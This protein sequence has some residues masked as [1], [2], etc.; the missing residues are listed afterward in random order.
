MSEQAVHHALRRQLEDRRAR[1]SASVAREGRDAD[2]VQLLRQVDSVLARI[3]TED[4]ARCLVCNEHVDESELRFNPLAEYCLCD[5]SAEQ[6]QALQ[7]DL[8]RARRIQAALLPDPELDSASWQAS[9]RYE[10]AGIVSG[11]F[12][13][14]WVPPGDA[15]FVCFAVGDVAGKGVAASLLMAHL[16]AAIRS[17]IDADVPL[18]DLVRRVNRKLLGASIPTHYATLACGRAHANGLV[19][20]VNAGHCPPLVL[21]ALG[22]DR[23][24]ATGFPVGLVD[25][26][27]YEVARLRLD[28]GDTL[29]LYTDGLSEARLPSGEE[30]G[31]GRIERALAAHAGAGRPRHIVRELRRDLDSFLGET[32]RDDDLTL[33]VLRRAGEAQASAA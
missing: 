16:Q 22:I 3:G 7:R 26:R 15:E 6:E 28:P 24:H 2:L 8:E 12:C 17:M 25:E 30:Y 5:L 31:E 29:L 20:I 32:P 4:Y 21:R 14:L 27:P 33:L 19:E 10:P 13:D 18:P 11:D 23:V 9:Y 1:L